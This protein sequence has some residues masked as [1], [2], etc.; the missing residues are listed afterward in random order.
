MMVWYGASLFNLD[1]QPEFSQRRT[2][3]IIKG[4]DPSASRLP[5]F[6][7]NCWQSAFCKSLKKVCLQALLNFVFAV[8]ISNCGKQNVAILGSSVAERSAVMNAS[9]WKQP[10]A[11]LT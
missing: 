8:T 4:Y 7:I 1:S 5:G 3:Q 9:N 11:E 6:D 10:K 2:L